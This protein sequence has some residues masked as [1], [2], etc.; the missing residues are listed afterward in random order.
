MEWIPFLL[1]IIAAMLIAIFIV[2][3]DIKIELK[4][5]RK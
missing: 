5:R 4:K 2:L 1:K 3:V